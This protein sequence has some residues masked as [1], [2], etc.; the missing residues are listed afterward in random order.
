MNPEFLKYVD[1]VGTVIVSLTAIG[2]LA[3]V[4][5]LKRTNGN[6]NNDVLD[7]IKK[8][9]GNHLGEVN[10]KLD[11]LLRS[12]GRMDNRLDDIVKLLIR[13]DA[14]LSKGRNNNNH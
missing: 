2:A 9:E 8:L 10:T 7:A 12:E 4:A 3:K 14:K 1:F 13:I 6:H 5:Q 11:E